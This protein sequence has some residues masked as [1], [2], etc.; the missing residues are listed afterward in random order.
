MDYKNMFPDWRELLSLNIEFEG[1][2]FLM[3]EPS[4]QDFTDPAPSTSAAAGW[5][6]QTHF[7]P[8]FA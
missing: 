2:N 1:D 8:F 4:G 5:F 3:D 6:E 7:A